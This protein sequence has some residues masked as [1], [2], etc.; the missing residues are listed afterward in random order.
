MKR[1][2][3][4]TALSV[5]LSCRLL[6]AGDVERLSLVART[7]GVLKYYH[8]RIASG[9][10]DPDSLLFALLQ[11]VKDAGKDRSAEDD[12]LATLVRLGP[13]GS[14][15]C[16]NAL[17]LK[18]KEAAAAFGW[19]DSL[20]NSTLRGRLKELLQC[21]CEAKHAL[22][23]ETP[24]AA[25]ITSV[26]FREKGDTLQV[27]DLDHRYL[28]LFRVWNAIRYFSPLAQGAGWDAALEELLPAFRN[29]TDQ[30]SYQLA[31]M[32]M[33]VL[34]GDGQAK[35]RSRF[36]QDYW[37]SFNV[38][39]DAVLAEGEV[40][41]ARGVN[42][43]LFRVTG[44]R[45][46]DR[47]LRMGNADIHA[48]LANRRQFI[49]GSRQSVQD[50]RIM[51]QL[52]LARTQ[53]ALPLTLRR[54]GQELIDTVQRLP[55]H[56]LGK[57]RE[58]LPAVEP[59]TN[60]WLLRAH[61]I[62][63]A[64][65]LRQVLDSLRS[66]L[67]LVIDL[68]EN[69]APGMEINWLQQLGGDR[70]FLLPQRVPFTLR[71]GYYALRTDTLRPNAKFPVVPFTGKLVLLVNEQTQGAAERLAFLLQQLP[72]VT[73]V[74]SPSAGACGAMS[75]LS[76]PGGVEVEFTGQSIAYPDGT[77]LSRNGLKVDRPVRPTAAMVAAGKDA[78]LEAVR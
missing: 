30:D 70:A 46:G 56:E 29:A 66:S 60:G 11:Q 45:A 61:R 4:L 33:L 75:F 67:R 39:F 71:P 38:P 35:V 54:N 12:L 55:V 62:N 24:N 50:E 14:G 37:G 49:P 23:N 52:F 34:L 31:C 13:V 76:L 22:L 59:L 43:S 68:R 15:A 10:V 41:V 26:S 6:A 64:T 2:L 27:P 47:I 58:Q 17:L 73:T 74:G 40:L 21:R 63:T 5:L 36:L 72:A 65:Q 32:R 1:M 18:G 51:R 78:V 77:L 3:M 69:I 19:I 9:K 16:D 8:P 7:W 20:R 42:D 44:L 48:R 25:L 28:A 53:S 57:L